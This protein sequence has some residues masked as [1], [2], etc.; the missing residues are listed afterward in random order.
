MG[1]FSDYWENLILDALFNKVALAE[2]TIWVGVCNSDTALSDSATPYEPTAAS[3]GRQDT[4]ST[5]WSAASGGAL[6]NAQVVE[7]TTAA[8]SWCTIYGF[9]G[10]DASVAGNVLF[11][12][13]LDAAQ[14]IS[15]GTVCRF[16]AGSLEAQLD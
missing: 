14:E 7:F 6:S 1:S 3:Y 2:V 12:G 13:T 16:V 8:Q 10:F 11:C 15:M 4:S 9:A 5:T